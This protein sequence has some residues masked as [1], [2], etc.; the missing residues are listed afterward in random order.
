MAQLTLTCIVHTIPEQS[1]PTVMIDPAAPVRM[2]IGMNMVLR[3]RHQA[4]YVALPVADPGD[5]E[6]R[7]VGI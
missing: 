6:N 5:I 7:A 4:E 3:M 2:L 1:Q